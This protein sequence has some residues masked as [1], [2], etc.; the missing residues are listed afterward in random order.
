VDLERGLLGLV[1]TIEGLLGRNNRGL[2]LETE[3]TAAGIRHADD[4]HNLSAKVDTNVADNHRSL[5]QC[6]SL[7]HSGHGV[8]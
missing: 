4:V 5:G 7:A 2:S 1:S 3:N 6:S 8:S